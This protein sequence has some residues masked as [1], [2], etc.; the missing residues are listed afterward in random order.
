MSAVARQE[1]PIIDWYGA[2]DGQWRDWLH[3]LAFRHPAKFAPNLIQRIYAHGF[4]RGWWRKGDTVADPFGGIAGGGIMAGYAGLNWFGVELES[5]KSD[6][7][8]SPFVELGNK[9]IALHAPKWAALGLKVDVRLVQGDSRRFAEICGGAAGIVTSPPFIQSLADSPSAS[10]RERYGKSM[11]RSVLGDGYGETAGQIGALPSGN[12]DSIVTSPPYAESLKPETDEQTRRKQARIAQSKTRYDGRKLEEPSGGKAGLGGGY[13]VSE[14]QIGSLKSGEVDGII[15][16]PPWAESLSSGKISEEMKEEMRSRGHKPSASGESAD[17]GS[18]RG[19]IGSLK[20][21]DVSAIVTSPPYAECVKGNHEEKESAADSR[22]ARRTPGGSLGQSCRNGGYGGA[23]GQI[24]SLKDGPVDAVVTSPPFESVEP[25]QDKKFLLNDGRKAKPQ[26]QEGY[27]KSNGQIG[28]DSGETYWQAMSQVYSQCL[29]AL[30]PNGVLV[31]VVKDYVKD[32][33]RVPLCDQTLRL[34]THLGFE[35]VE[36]IRAWL[37][38]ETR[39]QSLWG[40][41][42]VKRTERKSFF[43]RLAEKKGS[44]QI[45]WEEVIVVRKPDVMPAPA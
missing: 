22:A 20:S 24:G 45:D 1:I 7:P 33:K 9:N 14:G 36:R 10:V 2:Y 43:R 8:G 5:E 27:G 11:G 18:S 41:E 28:I 31:C 16:S 4:E 15:T 35:P 39:S 6:P 21:G 23:D 40:G 42:V 34:L 12:V 19:Q 29:A 25:Y 30:R 37:V 38:T 13:G 3:P 26:G 44:P 32:K 17:Y